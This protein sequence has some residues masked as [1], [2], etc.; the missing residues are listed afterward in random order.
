RSGFGEI[1]L[2]W[3]DWT[4][5]LPYHWHW[6][7]ENLEVMDGRPTVAAWI[8]TESSTT[9]KTYV[10]N[11]YFFMVDTAGNQLPYIDEVVSPIVSSEVYQMKIISGEAD[12]AYT[13]TEFAN[14]PLYKENEASGGYRVVPIPGVLASQAHLAFNLN[15]PDLVLRKL[16]QDKR[17]RQGL[18]IAIN[19]EEI[20]DVVYYGLG[21]PRYGTVLF[22]STKNLVF[23]LYVNINNK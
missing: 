14:Y 21:V 16:Y 13:E 15:E 9:I 3:D 5:S 4:Q 8:L 7:N 18:S 6:R 17:F 19:R 12:I 10:R 11:P 23:K 2:D 22:K 20:N 1:G